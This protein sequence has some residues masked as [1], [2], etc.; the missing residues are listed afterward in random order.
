MWPYTSTEQVWLEP[1]KDWAKGR[2][3]TNPLP[4]PANDDE[5][6]E[7]ARPIDPQIFLGK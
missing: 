4:T 7:D 6:V 3:Q 1:T 2:L 5:R